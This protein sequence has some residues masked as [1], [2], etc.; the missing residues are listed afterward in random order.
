MNYLAQKKMPPKSSVKRTLEPVIK[1]G[2]ININ[3]NSLVN[4]KYFLLKSKKKP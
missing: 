4:G 2:N 1:K 3:G